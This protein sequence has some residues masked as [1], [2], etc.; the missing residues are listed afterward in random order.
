MDHV[1]DTIAYA[2]AQNSASTSFSGRWRFLSNFQESRI[3]LGELVFPT[4]EHAYQACKSL[5][6][7]DWQLILGCASPGAAKKMGQRLHLR[8]NWDKIKLAVMAEIVAAKFDQNPD[9]KAQLLATGDSELVE[10]NWWGDTFWGV[11]KGVGQNHLGK[12]LM[13]YR[14]RQREPAKP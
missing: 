3:Q 6:P 11:C 1:M 7:K 9:L 10:N 14:D 12:I 8:P 5:D 13:A 4:A 2:P